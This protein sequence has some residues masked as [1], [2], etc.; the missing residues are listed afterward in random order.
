MSA[1]TGLEWGTV[2]QWAGIVATAAAVVIA[3]LK[4][5]IVRLWRKPKLTV[6]L[7]LYA[8]DCHKMTL[9]LTDNSRVVASAPCWYL[10]LWIENTG[11]ARAEQVQV[12]VDELSRREPDGFK[13]YEDFMPMN[14]VWSHGHEVF[15][16]GLSPKMGKHCDFGHIIDPASRTAF[17]EDREDVPAKETILKLD[18]EHPPST[19]GHLI[20]QGTYRMKLRVAGSN[21]SQPVE[22]ELNFTLTGNWFPDQERMFT[23][24]FRLE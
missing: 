5:D 10:R 19:L 11:N 12:F 15:A 18:L 23:E 16:A 21:T 6:Q 7:R 8:P 3:L 22:K 17:G 20:P 14:L 24:G 2:A 13:E 1:G 4:E 9:H